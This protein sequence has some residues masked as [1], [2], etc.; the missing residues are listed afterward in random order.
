MADMPV[1]S[2][3]Y[4]AELVA[5]IEADLTNPDAPLSPTGM[6]DMLILKLWAEVQSLKAATAFFGGIKPVQRSPQ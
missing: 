4:A 6:R 1:V 2:D 3:E 5:R